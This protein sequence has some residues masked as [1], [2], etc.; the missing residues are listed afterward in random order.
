MIAA[1]VLTPCIGRF[2]DALQINA[3]THVA[4]GS[5]IH[6][7]HVSYKSQICASDALLDSYNISYHI[8]LPCLIVSPRE[9]H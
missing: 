6:T 3:A 1:A 8:R 2:D 7:A 5:V 4:S 9:N